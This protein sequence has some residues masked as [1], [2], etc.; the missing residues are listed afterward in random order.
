MKP[1]VLAVNF[2]SIITMG[3]VVALLLGGWFGLVQAMGTPNPV[4]VVE[5]RSMLP[6]LRNG[7]LVIV[8]NVAP[9]QLVEEFKAEDE[10]PIIVFYSQP[11][12]KYIVH[13]IVELEYS[14]DGAFIGF[15]TKGDHNVVPDRGVVD[16]DAVVGKV[17]GYIPSVGLAVIFLRSP[18]GITLTVLLMVILA[19]WS[20]LEGKGKRAK[21]A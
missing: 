6:T 5:G 20:L 16:P 7:D 19:F 17:V 18:P 9:A 4:M 12:G 11:D 14:Q 1:K 8:K 13:R 21:E 2:R 10:L 3:L 15:K